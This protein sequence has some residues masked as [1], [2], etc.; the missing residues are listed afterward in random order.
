MEGRTLER[1]FCSDSMVSQS[2]ESSW[3]GVGLGV[4]FGFG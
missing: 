2:E 3:L 4:G 1:L